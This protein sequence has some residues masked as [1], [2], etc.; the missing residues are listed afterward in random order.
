MT[1][2][3]MDRRKKYTIMVLKDSLMKLLKDKQISYITV[4]EICSLADINR[5]TFYSHYT[6]Q[7][8]LLDTIEEEIIQD[9]Q[10]YMSQYNFEK[11]DQALQMIEKL[12][13]YFA[14][15]HEVCT[16]LLN[17]KTNTTFETKVINF[18]H[19]VFMTSWLADTA[20]DENL[21]EY[22]ST[23]IISGSIHAIKKWLN[24]GMDHSPREM[25]EI[26]NGVINR[27]LLGV[28]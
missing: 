22:L 15:K 16:T 14:S 23:F 12:L 3:K 10:G 5:S 19:Q 25:A 4:K 8:D 9:M 27:G 11:E 26:I 6:D 7:Y 17:E 13:E 24:N 28:R 2:P 1:S 20:Y 18:A 21:S